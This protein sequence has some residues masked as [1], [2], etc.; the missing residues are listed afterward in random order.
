MLVFPSLPF[1]LVLQIAPVENDNSYDELKRDAKMC[2]SLMSQ[3]LLYPQQVPLV[4]QVLKQV[5]LVKTT[6]SFM[7]SDAFRD[8]FFVVVLLVYYY[9]LLFKQLCDLGSKWGEKRLSEKEKLLYL[10]LSQKVFNI[11]S[12]SY[13]IYF[14]SH[15]C[16]VILFIFPC[17]QQEA[18]LG[19]LGIPY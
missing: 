6:Q 15:F 4:L 3:G 9:K 19:M 11:F 16:F 13:V 14:S 7:L 2:L 17:R 10:Q 18:I 12:F 1:D 8:G 5:S